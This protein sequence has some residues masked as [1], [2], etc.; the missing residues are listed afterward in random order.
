MPAR[1]TCSSARG[2]PGPSNRSSP[3]RTERGATGS[4]TPSRSPGTRWSSG[5]SARSARPARGAPPTCSCAR[6]RPGPSSRSSW[7]RT[8]RVE[9][10]FGVSVSVFGDTAVVGAD[11]DDTPGGVDAGS[12]YVFVR[13]GTS[14]TEQQHLRASDGG[15]NDRF[16]WSVSV[17]GD[18][19]VVGMPFADRQGVQGAGSA[20]VFVRS[21]TAW[22]EQ[23]RPR[24]VGRHHD[25]SAGRCRSPGT[26]W[27]SG[28]RACRLGVRVRALG[29]D[30]DPAAEAPGLRRSRGRRVRRRGVGLR[31]HGR[32]RGVQ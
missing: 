4:A 11:F 24:R 12:A 28:S 19:I 21:G 29:N 5:W 2:R 31:G 1:R 16:G 20:H 6:G 26:P 7:R 9:D 23:Q 13:A 17:S 15:A 10:Q 27:S 25:T 8:E 14:W 32:G 22:T 3:P 18:T 30:L